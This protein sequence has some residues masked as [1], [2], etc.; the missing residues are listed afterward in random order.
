MIDSSRRKRLEIAG[1]ALSLCLHPYGLK[2]S[3]A[4]RSTSSSFVDDERRC[5]ASWNEIIWGVTNESVRYR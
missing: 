4:D 2:L 3:R 1:I 5:S